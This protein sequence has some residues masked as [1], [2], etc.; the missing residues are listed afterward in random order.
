M[1]APLDS[2]RWR[3]GGKAPAELGTSATPSFAEDDAVLPVRYCTQLDLDD[4]D[5]W[6]PSSRRDGDDD[7]YE[8]TFRGHDG[9][10]TM[11]VHAP[12]DC[13]S[14][15]RPWSS[16]STVTGERTTQNP[17]LVERTTGETRQ[18]VYDD[19]LVR[20]VDGWRIAA[21]C[22]RFIVRDGLSERQDP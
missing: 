1:A 13:P 11:T 17:L 14:A 21:R 5:A 8:H 7:L 4:F 9:L 10:C 19:E 20:T 12:G 22:C 3:S 18:S 16:G 6:C 15:A 2:A